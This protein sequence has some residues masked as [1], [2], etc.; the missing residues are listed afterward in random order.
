[1]VVAN[2]RAT[3]KSLHHTPSS[4]SLSAADSLPTA[5]KY[6]C[7]NNEDEETDGNETDEDSSTPRASKQELPSNASHY[8][9]LAAMNP[10]S[11]FMNTL[12]DTHPNMLQLR[13]LQ[14]MNTAS[15]GQ[16]NGAHATSMMNTIAT[17]QR[18]LFMKILS[19]P[20]AA[21]HAAQAAQAAMSASQAK[22]MVSPASLLAS[23]HKQNS[24]SRKRKSTP[25][26]RVITHPHP[27][28]TGNNG[29]V[30][31]W[32]RI[33]RIHCLVSAAGKRSPARFTRQCDRS[34]ARINHQR[35]STL[36]SSV[37]I[38]S[39]RSSKPCRM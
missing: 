18:D 14:M 3:S 37:I 21:A 36:Q 11:I 15:A 35:P 13:L 12:D 28:S 22:T 30:R 2:N 24:S 8:Q 10:S 25:E 32:A 39:S 26:K 27:R 33:A 29:E 19:D 34:S 4:S 31:A 9:S 6:P 20:M 23:P 16:N 7:N 5:A 38:I 1:M 17:M